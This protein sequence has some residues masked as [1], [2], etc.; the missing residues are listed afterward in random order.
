[1]HLGRLICA[2]TLLFTTSAAAALPVTTS[3][4]DTDG[5]PSG[6]V[7]FVEPADGASFPGTPDAV[8]EVVVEFTGAVANVDLTIDGEQTVNCPNANASQCAVDVTLAP[9]NHTISA[10]GTD[11]IGLAVAGA[12]AEIGV[13][14]TAESATTG[15]P[16]GS[17][18]G[19][20]GSSGGSDGST[21]DSDSGGST[22]DKGCDC[23]ANGRP[24][25]GLALLGLAAL[26]RR[27][28]KIG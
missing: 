16:D 24:A 9:G 15:G 1:M 7:T 11:T 5:L 22:P 6:T 19:S 21:G 14:V 20:D 3:E 2:F 23:D 28:R 27:R 8:V 18:G 26:V 13:A 17:T 25:P 12:F 4:S 10:A